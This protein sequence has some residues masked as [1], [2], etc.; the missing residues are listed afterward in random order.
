LLLPKHLPFIAG[1]SSAAAETLA[2][3]AAQDWLDPYKALAAH[4]Y[5]TGLDRK[6]QALRALGAPALV[7]KP[8]QLESAVFDAYARLKQRRSI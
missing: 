6:V 7:A 2:Q 1:L 3:S 4:E 5:C 8:D